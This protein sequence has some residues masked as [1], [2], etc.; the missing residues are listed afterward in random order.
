MERMRP[1][2]QAIPEFKS[3]AEEFEFWSMTGKGSNSTKYLDRSRA[4]RVRTQNLKLNRMTQEREKPAMIVAPR[5]KPL[6]K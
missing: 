3:E 5:G 2:M 1:K 4:K 6:S